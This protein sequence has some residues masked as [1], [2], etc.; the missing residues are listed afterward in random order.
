MYVAIF[1]TENILYWR[2]YEK[3]TAMQLVVW[4]YMTCDSGHSS[5]GPQYKLQTWPTT[6]KYGLDQAC[7]CW[8]NSSTASIAMHIALYILHAGSACL[9]AWCLLRGSSWIIP[10]GPVCKLYIATTAWEIHTLY[11]HAC[12]FTSAPTNAITPAFT[13]ANKFQSSRVTLLTVQETTMETCTAP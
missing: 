3:S 4:Q 13:N 9:H 11:T 10:H 6:I 8:S 1:H 2:I 12:M 7:M 5:T